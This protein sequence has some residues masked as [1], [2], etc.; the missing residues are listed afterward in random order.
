MVCST[1]RNHMPLIPSPRDDAEC[2]TTLEL[3]PNS[4]ITTLTLDNHQLCETPCYIPPHKQTVP[5]WAKPPRLFLGIIQ[6]GLSPWME[7]DAQREAYGQAAKSY[8]SR[9]MCINNI[10]ASEIPCY[11]FSL[12][13]CDTELKQPLAGSPPQLTNG[14]RRLASVWNPHSNAAVRNRRQE[15]VF[16]RTFTHSTVWW[17]GLAALRYVFVLGK[18]L[19]DYAR[20]PQ[21]PNQSKSA[22]AGTSSSLTRSRQ[23][24]EEEVECCGNAGRGGLLTN[25]RFHVLHSHLSRASILNGLYL[26]AVLPSSS[27]PKFWAPTQL[28]S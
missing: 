14:E 25:Q 6:V 17:P 9:L 13:T 24:E 4:E 27:P 11:V 2:M 10:Q 15:R 18:I 22:S 1:G 3:V 8:R 28:K 7:K 21:L 5:E 12:N 19:A 20:L 16:S 26:L 23:D